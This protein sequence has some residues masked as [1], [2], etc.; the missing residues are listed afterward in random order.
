[1]IRIPASS[2]LLEACAAIAQAR[3][4]GMPVPRSTS[5]HIKYAMHTTYRDLLADNG[6]D[7]ESLAAVVGNR[8]RW[9]APLCRLMVLR[10]LDFFSAR[11]GAN[12]S[13][14]LSQYV[15]NRNVRTIQL[16]WYRGS[17]FSP[18]YTPDAPTLYI[19][20]PRTLAIRQ[21][22]M[23][24]NVSKGPDEYMFK[25][26][27]LRYDIDS[28][29][30]PKLLPFP[31]FEARA[32]GD[33]R[34]LTTAGVISG[35]PGFICRFSY[36]QLA[37]LLRKLTAAALKQLAGEPVTAGELRVA[38]LFADVVNIVYGKSETFEVAGTPTSSPVR[39]NSADLADLTVYGRLF[40]VVGPR[41]EVEGIVRGDIRLSE[42]VTHD[43]LA[44][45][46]EALNLYQGI[47]EAADLHATVFISDQQ[48]MLTGSSRVLF[49]DNAVVLDAEVLSEPELIAALM[50]DHIASNAST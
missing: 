19:G 35:L 5:K 4:A 13:R 29:G 8:A 30:V 39:I 7:V 25:L 32:K 44:L 43:A 18:S 37:G 23:F 48:P 2:I 14:N 9:D 34:T 17:D 20:D 31:A 22:V 45:D 11:L 3:A 40:L 26:I 42:V 41:A 6:V 12:V 49:G 50:G 10:F 33:D 28:R 15:T 24:P 21:R 16:P 46:L 1:M 36:C 47:D 27:N 38:R